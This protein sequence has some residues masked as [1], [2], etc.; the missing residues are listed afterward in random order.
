MWGLV[1]VKAGVA[2]L[3]YYTTKVLLAP[4]VKEDSEIPGVKSAV[5][6]RQ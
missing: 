5:L 2:Y 4:A 1:V 3:A 6:N